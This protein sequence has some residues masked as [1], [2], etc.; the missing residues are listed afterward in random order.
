ML[1]MS[2]RIF[3]YFTVACF[4][5]GTVGVS[6][7]VNLDIWLGL[8]GIL[9]GMVF[10]S[11]VGLV[12]YSYLLGKQEKPRRILRKSCKVVEDTGLRF[13]NKIK[14]EYM[15]LS[16]SSEAELSRAYRQSASSIE[17]NSIEY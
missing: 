15:S 8:I 3:I 9:M 2:T 14:Q 17:D 11:E 10:G 5:M 13:R 7:G 6:G 16:N 1:V 4:S 12:V